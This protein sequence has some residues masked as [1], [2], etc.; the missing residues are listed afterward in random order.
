MAQ[1]ANKKIAVRVTLNDIVYIVDGQ[2]LYKTYIDSIYLKQRFDTNGDIVQQITYGVPSTEIGDDVT[3]KFVI[4]DFGVSIFTSLPAAYKKFTE[5]SAYAKDNQNVITGTRKEEYASAGT[6]EE[7]QYDSETV[8][9]NNDPNG[10]CDYD[11]H[12]CEYYDTCYKKEKKSETVNVGA[13]QSD[14]TGYIKIKT[15]VPDIPVVPAKLYASQ[16]SMRGTYTYYDSTGQLVA[17]STGGDINDYTTYTNSSGEKAV[18]DI[19]RVKY[20]DR[21][22]H[23]IYRLGDRY[24][25]GPFVYQDG[26]EIQV[27]TVVLHKLELVGNADVGPDGITYSSDGQ[28]YY[29]TSENNN[30]IDISE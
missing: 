23:I 13:G 18:G 1:E 6:G 9:T 10:I 19:I 30:I 12:N 25:S 17:P 8:L 3:N 24:D 2:G 11:C 4:G 5:L 27:G 15:E 14:L 16:V 7:A 22:G 21:E 20:Y 28:Q 26:S 29:G